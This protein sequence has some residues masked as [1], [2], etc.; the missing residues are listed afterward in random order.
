[1]DYGMPAQI[2][3]FAVRLLQ[4]RQPEIQKRYQESLVD[5]EQQLKAAQAEWE[6]HET[7]R[8]AWLRRLTAGDLEEIKHILTEIFTGLHLPFQDETHCGLL[9]DT[10]DLLSVNLDLPETEQVVLFTRKRL[11]KNGETLEV[12][13]DKVESNRDYF[14]LVTGECASI[15]AEVFP[16]CHCAK[17][18]VWLHTPSATRRGKRTPSTPTSWT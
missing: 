17:P 3:R 16:T 18:S 15:A 11:L 8:I 12:A 13:R 7:E 2:Y 10:A 5:H 4:E 14:D 6:A 9:F 1:M